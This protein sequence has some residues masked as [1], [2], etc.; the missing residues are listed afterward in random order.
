MESVS[1]GYIKKPNQTKPKQTKKPH[2][3]QGQETERA[4]T[5]PCICVMNRRGEMGGCSVWVVE[6]G[7]EGDTGRLNPNDRG[8]SE[9]W[10]R[11]CPWSRWTIV[12]GVLG[13]GCWVGA[14]CPGWPVLYLI[15]HLSVCPQPWLLWLSILFGVVLCPELYLILLTFSHTKLFFP[16]PQ[17]IYGS[18]CVVLGT[19]WKAV[20]DRKKKAVSSCPSLF[21]GRLCLRNK[22]KAK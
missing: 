22:C 20:P 21:G 1:G 8:Y 3:R 2:W 19:S 18:F 9:E 7:G 15:L 11:L 14:L 16:F 17:C 6:H 10:K 13:S 4:T 12:C 5:I